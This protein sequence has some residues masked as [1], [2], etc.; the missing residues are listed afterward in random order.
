M[1]KLLLWTLVALALL[2]IA[3]AAFVFLRSPEPTPEPTVPIT[4]P[5]SD[6]SN[7]GGVTLTQETM[8]IRNWNGEP[9]VV[10]DFISSRLAYE[11]PA[12]PGK[13]YLAGD[14]DLCL[15]MGD[16]SLINEGYTIAYFSEEQA[17]GIT[18]GE[19]PIG[20]VRNLAEAH[21]Q[22][23]LGI[24]PEYLCTL[25]YTL[26]TTYY[27]NQLYSDYGNLGF[28]FCPGAVPLP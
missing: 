15:T 18:L 26:N 2:A 23:T 28:S 21:L 10:N 7:G 22:Q 1:K 12:N 20:E 25:T 24:S 19:E 6:S 5:V 11:D 16:C 8:T 3:F 14:E 17:F 4:F 27:V 13:Y 9:L